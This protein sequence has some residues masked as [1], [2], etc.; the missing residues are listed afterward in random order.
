MTGLETEKGGNFKTGVPVPGLANLTGLLHHLRAVRLAL[1]A[2]GM[3][4]GPG[5]AE[6][7]SEE[8]EQPHGFL[9]LILTPGSQR[10]V[11]LKNLHNFP[12]IFDL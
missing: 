8:G 7:K 1:L 4:G 9:V 6:Q 5:E 11:L 12:L 10:S 2:V 3:D